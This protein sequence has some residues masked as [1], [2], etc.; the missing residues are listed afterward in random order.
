VLV[1]VVAFLGFAFLN[2][3]ELFAWQ[4]TW[5]LFGLSR[6]GV[7]DHWRFWQFI[8]SPFVHGGLTHLAFNMLALWMLGPDVEN[9]LGRVRFLLFCLSCA[10]V[11]EF[12]F[13]LLAGNR[14]AIL[15]GWSGVIFG[16]L[17]AQA[18]L[19]PDSRLLLFGVFPLKMRHA[20]FLLGAMELYFTLDATR[21]SGT[22]HLAHVFGALG[23][24][25]WMFILRRLADQRAKRPPV[26]KRV[27]LP[28]PRF[29]PDRSDI[30]HEL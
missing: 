10:L 15:I 17:A 6:T 20:V 2:L 25:A 16:I 1:N 26:A 8:S 27:P 21:R 13:L 24:C 28:R 4:R 18:V 19:R 3:S 9:A 12:G 30:P 11:S 14:G 23:G 5:E 7:V 22:A 29:R